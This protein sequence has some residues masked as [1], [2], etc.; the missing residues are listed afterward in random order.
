MKLVI[1]NLDY[2][3]DFF[4]STEHFILGFKT[5]SYNYK[6]NCKKKFRMTVPNNQLSCQIKRRID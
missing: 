3:H 4:G 5:F 6:F 2:T 1:Q